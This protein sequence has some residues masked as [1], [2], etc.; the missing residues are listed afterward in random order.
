MWP[1][2]VVPKVWVTTQTRVEKGKKWVAPK[3]SKAK[4]QFRQPYL[5]ND[6]VCNKINCFIE[7]GLHYHCLSV[8]ACSQDLREG[9]TRGTSYPGPVG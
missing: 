4:L 7:S 6:Y 1:R 5:N 2:D 3:R 9:G 8:P